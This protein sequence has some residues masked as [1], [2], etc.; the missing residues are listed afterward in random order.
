[1]DCRLRRLPIGILHGQDYATRDPQ[2]W[3]SGY[4]WSHSFSSQGKLP[5]KDPVDPFFRSVKYARLVTTGS[6]N[7]AAKT[8][9]AVFIFFLTFSG[10]VKKKYATK[11][12]MISVMIF[13]NTLN[14]LTMYVYFF[15]YSLTVSSLAS[16]SRFAC[17]SLIF[18][19]TM[20]SAFLTNSSMGVSGS[21]F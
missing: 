5:T 2:A 9:D 21:S 16:A 15:N 19:A 8:S 12:T 18:A 10:D 17:R 20:S 14:I 7:C 13:N 11:K 1:M 6:F 4:P 3:L